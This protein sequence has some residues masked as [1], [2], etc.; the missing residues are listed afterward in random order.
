MYKRQVGV[1][2]ENGATT[3][4]IPD[5]VGYTTPNEFKELLKYLF[6][7]VNGLDKAMLSVHC[8]NDLGLARCV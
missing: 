6:E 1:A 2:L 5:T 4:N 8:H 3:I 7:R